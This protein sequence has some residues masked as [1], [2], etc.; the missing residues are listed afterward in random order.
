MIK[1]I[2]HHYNTS[3]VFS[4]RICFKCINVHK[5]GM[6]V[7]EWFKYNGNEYE[8]KNSLKTFAFIA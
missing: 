5:N 4:N 2:T 8:V 7:S 6:I 1:A 3:G